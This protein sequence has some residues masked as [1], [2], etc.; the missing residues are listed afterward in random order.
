[1]QGHL[2]VGALTQ[3]G[4]AHQAGVRLGDIILEVAGEPVDDLGELFRRVWSTG[5]AGARVPMT[6]ARGRSTSRILV[7]SAN[8]E[9]FLLKPKRH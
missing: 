2:V 9:D 7:E 3:G 4:P 5:A 1:M 6:V 8:R